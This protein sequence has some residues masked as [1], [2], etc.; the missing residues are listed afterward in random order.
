[1]QKDDGQG[2]EGFAKSHVVSQAASHTP[3]CQF[4]QP[5]EAFHLILTQLGLQG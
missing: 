5:M 3:A 4:G 1:M 2:L